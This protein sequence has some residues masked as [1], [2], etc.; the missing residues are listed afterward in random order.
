MM[1]KKTFY[2]LIIFMVF[3]LVTA[4]SAEA[5]SWKTHADVVEMVYYGLPWRFR[6]I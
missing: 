2:V 5:W 1:A 3:V 6:R 4:P